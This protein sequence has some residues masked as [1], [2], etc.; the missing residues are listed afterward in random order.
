MPRVSRGG[1]E[2]R[3]LTPPRRRAAPRAPPDAR[4]RAAPHRRRA[5]ASARRSSCRCCRRGL[6]ARGAR[7]RRRCAVVS[8]AR[9]PRPGDAPAAARALSRW[10]TNWICTACSQ[11]AARDQLERVHLDSKPRRRDAAACA[12]MHGKGY[13]SGARGP[14]LKIAVNTWL[15]A[16]CRACWRSPRRAP[17]TAAPAPSTCCCADRPAR[18]A[19]R[20]SSP[21][22]AQRATHSSPESLSAGGSRS[23]NLRAA[24]PSR[25]GRGRA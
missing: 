21:P 19:G 13:R 11:A 8:T 1:R 20:G 9:R 25:T 17:S 14:V 15:Q 16:P 10:R 5:P 6:A 7:R 18:P 4:R 12:S 3:P 2:V 22:G 24:R 23:H